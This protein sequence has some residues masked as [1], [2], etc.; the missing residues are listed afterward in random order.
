MDGRNLKWSCDK[1][2]FMGVVVMEGDCKYYQLIN[3]L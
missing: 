2:C 3:E 1:M